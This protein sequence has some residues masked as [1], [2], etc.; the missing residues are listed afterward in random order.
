[1]LASG[2]A[3]A[4]SAAG[5]GSALSAGDAEAIPGEPGPAPDQAALLGRAH[6]D[7]HALVKR[8]SDRAR[9][10]WRAASP[11]DRRRELAA[12][13][14]RSERIAA[15]TAGDPSQV[16]A[17]T[18]SPFP[19]SDFAIHAVLLPTGKVLLWGYEPF[20]QSTGQR[21]NDGAAFLWDPSRG[22]GPSSLTQV[23][24]PPLDHDGDPATPE[25]RGPVYCS[26]QTLLP[27]GEMLAVGGN[28]IWPSNDQNDEYT[29]VAGWDGAYTFDPWTETWR[30]QPTTQTRRD[31]TND[32]EDRGGRW[33]PSQ[34]L[35]GNGETAIVGGYDEHPPGAVT[36]NNDLELFRH[37]GAHDSL[38]EFDH[39]PQGDKPTSLYPHLFTLPDGHVLLAGPGKHDTDILRTSGSNRFRWHESLTGVPQ[40]PPS[41]RD[42]IG[43][44]AVLV[45]DGPAGSSTVNLLGGYQIPPSANAP[46]T[47]VVEQIDASDPAPAWQT[48]TPQNHGRSYGN[49]VLLPDGS[50]VTIGGGKG[51]GPFGSPYATHASGE[52]RRVELYDRAS[53]TWTLGP[54]QLEDRAYHSV[55]LLL[56]DGRVLSAGDDFNPAQPGYDP[57]TAPGWEDYSTADTAEIYS[58]PYL[59]RGARP[60]PGAVPSTAR[61]GDVFGVP[62]PDEDQIAKAVLMAPGAVTHGADMHQRAVPLEIT[63][64]LPGA[65]LNLRMPAN[66]NLAPPGYYMLFLV[67]RAGVPSVAKWIRLDPSAPDHPRLSPDTTAPRAGLRVTSGRRLLRRRGILRVRAFIG[68]RGTMSVRARLTRGR[69]VFRAGGGGAFATRGAAVRALRLRLPARRVRRLARRGG[70][71]V[72][73]GFARDAAGNIRVIRRARRL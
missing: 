48:L 40:I 24:P 43:G 71:V 16:G 37:S 41:S 20:D 70:R 15:R 36:R 55:A 72:V 12:E 22:T 26:G 10:E 5:A 42:R 54:A 30:F 6:A 51:R 27:N 50:M 32:I 60:K 23:N 67:N 29:D 45:P 64:V 33:Y 31:G 52:L 1:M 34:V 19:I 38:G 62:V 4:C 68:E 9:A 28:L 13:R 73:T 39:H 56:P 3:I 63:K 21:V 14:S 47:D 65:G 57:E 58:P 46:A 35:L 59:F 17:W 18:Q 44:N 11:E 66:G 49:T 53:D 7:E 61:F 2:L 25:I 69:V 8:Q